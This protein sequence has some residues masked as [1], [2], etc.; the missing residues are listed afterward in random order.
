VGG[1]LSRGVAGR[2]LRLVAATSG[3]WRGPRLLISPGITS[4]VGATV[5]EREEVH[6][7]LG[8][9]PWSDNFAV[10]PTGRF[11]YVRTAAMENVDRN[12]NEV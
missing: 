8:H 12:L 7:K 11:L 2:P 9:P 10:D 6:E 5:P 4:A 1:P 3:Y